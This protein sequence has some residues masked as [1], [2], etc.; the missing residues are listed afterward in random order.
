MKVS[1]SEDNEMAYMFDASADVAGDLSDWVSLGVIYSG[2]EV[3]LDLILTVPTS[4]SNE[5]QD[6]I[7]YLDWEF[8]V[9]ELPL[10]PGDPRPP[11][12]GDNSLTVILV[13]VMAVSLIAIIVLLILSRRKKDE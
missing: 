13:T 12:T 7:G 9:N 2:G 3:N 5:Y 11:Q 4:L 8:M 10:S 1:K 6:A